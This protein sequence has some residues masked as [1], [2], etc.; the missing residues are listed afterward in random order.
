MKLRIS[1]ILLLTGLILGSCSDV[2]HIDDHQEPEDCIRLSASNSVMITRS[3]LEY[4]AFEVG[5]KYHLYGVETGKDWS[6][7]N[8]VL[9]R[10]QAYETD[11]H[12]IYY[13]DDLHFRDKT[14]DFYGT[15]ICSTGDEYPA[16]N[17]AAGNSPVISLSLKDNVLDDLMYSNTLK[18]CTRASGLLQNWH[19]NISRRGRGG[20]SFCNR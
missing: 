15:T 3:G 8:T 19:G 7:G 20:C 5:T 18:G 11:K 10:A 12:L 17:T 6:A 1:Y 14:Y 9:N 4:E 16:D 2:M 13:G